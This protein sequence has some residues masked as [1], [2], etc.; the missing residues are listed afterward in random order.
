MRGDDQNQEDLYSYIFPEKQ[1]PGDHPLRAIRRMVDAILVELS[2]HFS[3][4]YSA[5]G[6]PSIP[7]EKLL[8]ALLLRIGNS[9][10]LSSSDIGYCVNQRA[11]LSVDWK[12]SRPVGAE[13]G[14]DDAVPYREADRPP[15]DAGGNQA[16]SRDE[17][18]PG[19]G[20]EADG[21]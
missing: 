21:G 18:G 8:R 9:S 14:V 12:H 1:V 10:A 5:V 6:R 20:S 15:G 19:S 3:R 2:P 11:C 4:I 7:P 17:D 16:G 13:P